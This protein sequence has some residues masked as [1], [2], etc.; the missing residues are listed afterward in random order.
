MRKHLTQADIDIT[1]NGDVLHEINETFTFTLSPPTNASIGDGVGLGTINSNTFQDE[2]YKFGSLA[3]SDAAVRQ[4]AIRTP[5]ARRAPL[6]QTT[7][8]IPATSPI[9]IA[10]QYST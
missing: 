9:G 3:H 2:A 4:K 10:A 1:V 7:T 5:I 8:R 6:S